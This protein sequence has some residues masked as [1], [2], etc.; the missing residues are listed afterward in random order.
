M[1]VTQVS[2]VL[3]KYRVS[4]GTNKGQLAAFIIKK[5]SPK[6]ESDVIHYLNKSFTILAGNLI[7]RS[8]KQI[9][10]DAALK[11]DS[12]HTLIDNAKQETNVAK[13]QA[14]KT[15]DE[16][17]KLYKVFKQMELSTALSRIALLEKAVANLCDNDQEYVGI[18][19]DTAKKD[20]GK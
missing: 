8:C 2:E 5:A 15:F 3:S 17:K 9:V 1:N 19:L 20:L 12:E 10:T 16:T 14:A 13:E 4:E 11:L 18:A 7:D 6:T